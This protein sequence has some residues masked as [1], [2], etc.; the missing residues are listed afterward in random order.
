MRSYV[1]PQL[2]RVFTYD[3]FLSHIKMKGV[4]ILSTRYADLFLKGKYGRDWRFTLADNVSRA[5]AQ[6]YLVD[7]FNQDLYG[8][9]APRE[10]LAARLDTPI[11]LLP[12]KHAHWR[13]INDLFPYVGRNEAGHKVATD[14]VR[15]EIETFNVDVEPYHT[16]IIRRARKD[17]NPRTPWIGNP[18]VVGDGSDKSLMRFDRIRTAALGGAN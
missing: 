6:Y 7:K 2:F 18:V 15:R 8:E 17:N 3:G 10:N 14:I 4:D 13:K 5:A 9:Y 1:H 11:T 12:E 16:I